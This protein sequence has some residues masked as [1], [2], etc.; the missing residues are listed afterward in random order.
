MSTY[1]SAAATIDE[2]STALVHVASGM[3]LVA[4][5]FEKKRKKPIVAVADLME[6]ASKQDAD[7][8][9]KQSKQKKQPSNS[10]KA[11]HQP[12]CKS[13]PNVD[14]DARLQDV[15]WPS[16]LLVQRPSVYSQ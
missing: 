6:A 13:V 15:L 9:R 10:N 14:V 5:R 3:N 16:S 1:E 12:N 8:P 2:P 4:E 11:Y 7:R